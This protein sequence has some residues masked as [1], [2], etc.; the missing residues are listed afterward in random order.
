MFQEACSNAV[1]HGQAQK[2]AVMF[3]LDCDTVCLT[4]SDDG[5]GFDIDKTDGQKTLSTGHRG[6][7]NMRER[8]HLIGGVFK[9]ISSPG[10]GCVVSAAVEI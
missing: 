5:A 2:I 6:I 3:S 7:A 4:I 9:I 1:R 10:K 8:I